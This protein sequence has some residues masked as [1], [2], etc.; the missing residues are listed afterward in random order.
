MLRMQIKNFS[1]YEVIRNK[2]LDVTGQAG[3][4][5]EEGLVADY[6]IKIVNLKGTFN[7]FFNKLEYKPTLGDNFI[8]LKLLLELP[9]MIKYGRW[10]RMDRYAE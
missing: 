5:Q 6:G 9:T 1:I 7:V 10:W 3:F 2:L 8:A 4:H